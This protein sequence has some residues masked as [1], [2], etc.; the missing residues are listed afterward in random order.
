MSESSFYLYTSIGCHLCEQAEAIL[1]EVLGDDC[2]RVMLME[3]SDSDDLMASYGLR[4]PVFAGTSKSGE[5]HELGWPFAAEDVLGFLA[6][7]QN[8]GVR[9]T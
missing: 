7:L 5:W 6:Q 9:V 8:Q 1:Q 4:I 2:E 3:I